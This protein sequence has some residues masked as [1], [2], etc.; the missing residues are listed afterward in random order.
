MS[1]WT[2]ISVASFCVSCL[3]L[4]RIVDVVFFAGSPRALLSCCKPR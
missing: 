4:P 2:S 1:S 3:S